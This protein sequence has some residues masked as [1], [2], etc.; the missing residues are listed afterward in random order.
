MY[1][2]FFERFQFLDTVFVVANLVRKHGVFHASKLFAEYI[3][4]RFRSSLAIRKPKF[5]QKYISLRKELRNKTFPEIEA[6]NPAMAPL[7]KGR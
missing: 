1:P 4:W 2:D 7:R 6:D 5:A 3:V